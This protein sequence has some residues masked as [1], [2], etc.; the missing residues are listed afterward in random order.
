MSICYPNW[1][2]M[3]QTGRG[4]IYQG[5][6]VG[7][8]IETFNYANFG[9]QINSVNHKVLKKVPYCKSYTTAN[10]VNDYLTSINTPNS[11]TDHFSKKIAHY[12]PKI[13]VT[14]IRSL[15]PKIEEI[16]EFINRNQISIVFVTET[17]LRSTIMDS[18]VD[19]TGYSLIRK[20]RS[21]DCHGG[22]AIYIRNN[23]FKYSRLDLLS[24]C[25]DHEILWLFLRPNRL[26][27]GFSS[28]I[29]AVVYHPFWTTAENDHMREHLFQ[30]LTLAKSKYPNCAIIIAGDF[31]RLDIKTIKKHF[32][33]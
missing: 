19:I 15:V 14:N 7:I 33:L 12:V 30:S 11:A 32:R 1:Y 6:Y 28:L 13:M 31:N 5:W 29:V 22:V 21:S 27:R 26:P 16:Q 10:P 25:E 24:C 3:R 20:D 9:T 23:Q 17:W 8:S 18:V 2:F 4:I